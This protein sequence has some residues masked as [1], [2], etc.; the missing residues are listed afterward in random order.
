MAAELSLIPLQLPWRKA[1]NSA[2]ARLATAPSSPL[3]SKVSPSKITKA[4][5]STSWHAIRED[6]CSKNEPV[7]SQRPHGPL[8]IRTVIVRWL[9]ELSR[10]MGHDPNLP[11]PSYPIQL[12]PT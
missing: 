4:K 3:W 1:T 7:H 9:E 8:D 11:V 2:T 6:G 5:S 10:I 12:D